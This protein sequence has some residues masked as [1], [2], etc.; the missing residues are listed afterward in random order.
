MISDLIIAKEKKNQGTSFWSQYKFNASVFSCLHY[1]A[2]RLAKKSKQRI[3]AKQIKK[4]V[5]T[6]IELHRQFF[7]GPNS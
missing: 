5:H 1:Q 3:K 2:P 6:G 4:G 7:Q